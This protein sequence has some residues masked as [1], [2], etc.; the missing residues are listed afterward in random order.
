[1]NWFGLVISLISA[2]IL[3]HYSKE[4]GII[5]IFILV[6]I[7]ACVSHV[8]SII[9]Y[10]KSGAFILLLLA[11]LAYAIT[12]ILK[13]FVAKFVSSFTSNFIFFAIIYEAVELLSIALIAGII[14][15][16]LILIH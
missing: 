9:I 7:F 12:S 15:L 3:Y 1:M 4:N 2:Y 5:N 11:L 13:A 6:F 16:L 10:I 8:S 14:R